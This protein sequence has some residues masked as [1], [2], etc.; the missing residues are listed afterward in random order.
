MDR[1]IYDEPITAQVIDKAIQQLKPNK[2][3][4]IDG[5]TAEFW[6]RKKNQQQNHTYSAKPISQN[7]T[8]KR[9]DTKTWKQ[10]W[11]H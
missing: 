1:K 6:R 5:I 3:P 11:S 4:G 7:T 8:S 10:A 9:N 2:S